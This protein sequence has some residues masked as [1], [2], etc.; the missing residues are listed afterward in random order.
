M[1]VGSSV[2]R[3]DPPLCVQAEVDRLLPSDD[4]ISILHESGSYDNAKT[5]P[6]AFL[7]PLEVM[8]F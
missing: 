2:L 3:A 7:Q 1:G 5:S 4:M 6:Q 8:L